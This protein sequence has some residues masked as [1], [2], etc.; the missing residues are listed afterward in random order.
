MATR[1]RCISKSIASQSFQSK[2]LIMNRVA[3]YIWVE[4]PSGMPRPVPAI[5]PPSFPEILGGT[6]DETEPPIRHPSCPLP[7]AGK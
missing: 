7:E 4:G 6:A 5:G 1:G 2:E 3:R